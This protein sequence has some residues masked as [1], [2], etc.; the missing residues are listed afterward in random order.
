MQ[1][2]F[3]NKQHVLI[4]GFTRVEQE[5]MLSVLTLSKDRAVIVTCGH[6]CNRDKIPLTTRL[7][8]YMININNMI[9]AIAAC[10][11]VPRRKSAVT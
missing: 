6:C 3:S 4:L 2:M 1:Y 5:L 8:I 11:E 7:S 10:N 9:Q